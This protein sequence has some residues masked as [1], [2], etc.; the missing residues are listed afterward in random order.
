MKNA[1]RSL[2]GAIRAFKNTLGDEFCHHP[3]M[4]TIT[5]KLCQ[6]IDGLLID[7]FHRNGLT[8]K[9]KIALFALGSYGRRELQLH[10][11]IDLLILHADDATPEALNQAQQFIRDCWDLGFEIS[12]QITTPE[13]CAD[14]ASQ[15][16]SVMSSLLDIHHLC[17]SGVLLEQL[18]YEI[19]NLQIWPDATY[20][21]AKV[22]EQKNRYLKYAETAFNLEP[23]VKNGPGGL[24]DI[25]ILSNISKRYLKTKHLSEAIA[26]G[27]IRDKEYETLH[28]CQLFLWKVRF[29]LHTINEKAEERLSFDCQI[30]LAKLFGYEDKPHSLAIE[31]FMKDYFKATQTIRVLNEILLQSFRESILE[32]PFVKITPLD[33]EFQLSST[34]IEVRHPE[35]FAKNPAALI[36]L[37]HWIAIKPE[38]EGIRASTIRMVRE[39]LFRINH[40]IQTAPEVIHWFMDIFKRSEDPFIALNK[41]SDYGVLSHYLDCFGQVAGQMQ[42]DLFHVYTVDQH[43][44]F[45]IRNISR[46]RQDA[47]SGTFRLCNKLIS[48]IQHPEILYLAALFHDIAKGRGG[49]HSLLGGE[50]A[51]QFALKH[52]LPEEQTE[53]LI[54]LVKHH[55]LMSQT[56]Q[57]KDIY[58]PQTIE[59]FTEALPKP[60][61]LDYLYLLTVAD[62]CATNPTLWNAWK[63]SLLQ[64][65]YHSSRAFLESEHARINESE[66]VRSKQNNALVFLQAEGLNSPEIQSLWSHFRN[67]YFLHESPEVIARHTHA[68]LTAQQIPLV[69]ISPHHSHGG[70]E[71]FLYMPHDDVHFALIT[72]VLAN[73]HVTIQEA[74]VTRC[75]TNFDL[76]TYII[77]NDNDQSL[78]S[79]T[80]SQKLQ[81]ALLHHL[82]NL[83]IPEVIQKRISRVMAHFELETN[84]SYSTDPISKTTVMFLVTNDRPGLLALISQV[85]LKL[86]IHLHNAKIATA[87][88]RVEDTFYITNSSNAPLLPLQQQELTQELKNTIHSKRKKN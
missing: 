42:Y 18:E 3:N 1:N 22:R 58:S 64:E 77:L 76:D 57:R 8:N 13:R 66:L 83:T 88:E 12:H 20:F 29:G 41:M 34:F 80:Q 4:T 23:D 15:D 73:H 52:Q 72:S 19:H 14:L 69:M 27:F 62:I 35:V 82:E 38:I 75:D 2:K 37:F 39:S 71:L 70:T 54:W 47:Y 33:D 81:K 79:S 7:L 31:Q 85:F 6:Y 11:D 53:L 48:S 36:K 55:L 30:K 78:L 50:E 44:L 56:A 21:E 24:R 46:F 10:S 49:D 28:Q 40:K 45:V 16:L 68:I 60:Y 74:L 9:S 65:L 87:G 84:V 59:A 86:G 5:H 17:G 43:T 61:Y 63:D 25:H 32:Q 67:R 26:F 51:K